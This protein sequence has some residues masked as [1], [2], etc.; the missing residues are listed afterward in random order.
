M[1]AAAHMLL[2][3][4]TELG[5]TVRPVG[6]RLMLRTGAKPIPGALLKLLRESKA[7]LMQALVSVEEPAGV[8]D[9]AAWWRRHYIV[10]V[11]D[12][13]LS[14]FRPVLHA[15]RLAWGELVS[16]WHYRYGHRRPAWQCAGCDAP[17]GGVRSLTL[18]DGNRVHFDRLDCLL[19]FGERWRDEAT[20]ALRALGL[21]APPELEPA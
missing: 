20:A 10:R 2:A 7:D 1:S 18:G 5:V 6:D 3:R 9:V 21:D 14:G 11:L 17:I 13:E 12:W 4:L 8:E 16:E 19:A 15:R